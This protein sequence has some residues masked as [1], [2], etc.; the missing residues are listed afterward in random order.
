M[1]RASGILNIFVMVFNVSRKLCVSS[2]SCYAIGSC[3]FPQFDRYYTAPQVSA[4]NNDATPL[5]ETWHILH[6][7]AAN[8]VLLATG[9]NQYG[10]S[11]MQA[12]VK[13]RQEADRAKSSPREELKTYLAAPLESTDNAVGWWGVRHLDILQVLPVTCLFS[14]TPLNIR[15]SH[16]LPATIWPS[17]VLPRR[18]SGLFQA[19]D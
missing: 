16:E 15:H 14:V 12:T 3:V 17:K 6:V 11:W 5:G 13:A 19:E 9:K 10:Y 18:L 8:V 7:M 1:P 4:N 2:L